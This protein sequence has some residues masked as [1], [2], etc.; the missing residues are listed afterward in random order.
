MAIAKAIAVWFLIILAESVLGVGRTLLLEPHIGGMRARQ[1][2]VFI[3]C[4]VIFAFAWLLVRWQGTCSRPQLLLIG[5]L[6]AALTICF[7]IGL[8]HLLGLSWD[9]ITEDYDPA[10]GGL[11]IFGLIFM[12][13]APLLANWARR[14]E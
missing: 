14:N 4:I 12:I 13:L 9:R 7:E 11:M 6:W 2:G 5:T 8:G 1:I 10:R 3:G